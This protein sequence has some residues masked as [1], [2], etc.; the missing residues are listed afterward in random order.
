MRSATTSRAAAPR[1]RLSPHAVCGEAKRN[2]CRRADEIE[3]PD[4]SNLCHAQTCC[5]VNQEAART[6][7][8]EITATTCSR[9]CREKLYS[10]LLSESQQSKRVQG[11]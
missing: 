8:A 7:A 3:L 11:K 9:I 10:F 1:A 5:I 2:G 4:E 6:S